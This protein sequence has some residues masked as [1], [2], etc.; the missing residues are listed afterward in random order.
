MA[1]TLADDI[2][3][4]ISLN[5][6]FWILNTFTGI[7]YLGFNWQYGSIG[8]DN[9]LAVTRQQAIIW[10]NDCQFTDAYMRHL[11]SVS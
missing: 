2:F 1:T 9:G 8:S 6:N 11:A 5:E 3:K 10:T 4:Y 7:C